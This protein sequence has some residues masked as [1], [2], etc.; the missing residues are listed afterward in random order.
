[1]STGITRSLLLLFSM[2]STWILNLSTSS[3]MT[4]PFYFTHRPRLIPYISD[5]GVAV[6]APFIT[7]WGIFLLIQSFL[8]IYSPRRFRRRLSRVQPWH[9]TLEIQLVQTLFGWTW[10][11]RFGNRS[12][13]D[14]VQ[15]LQ[16]IA[17]LLGTTL[18][19]LIGRANARDFLDQNGEGLVLFA[20]WWAI[21]VIKQFLASF[22]IDAWQTLLYHVS[23]DYYLFPDVDAFLFDTVGVCIAY[24]LSGLSDRE[25]VTFLVLSVFQ[26]FGRRPRGSSSTRAPPNSSVF[27]VTP[28]TSKKY[29]PLRG[30]RK[31]TYQLARWYFQ[32]LNIE[33]ADSQRIQCAIRHAKHQAQSGPRGPRP[34]LRINTSGWTR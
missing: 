23:I 16:S 19:L 34:Q 10:L 9:L 13:M 27:K 14:P 5:K 6:L 7:Y 15:D 11:K 1:M 21:P 31:Q 17:K 24:S 29:I 25:A 22:I 33:A 4:L 20:Y 26:T 32:A 18:P 28:S 8:R 30:F 12:T 2:D 3:N